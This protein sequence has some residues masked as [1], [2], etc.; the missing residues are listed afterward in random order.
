MLKNIVNKELIKNNKI[1]EITII[2]SVI[3]SVVKKIGLI[4]HILAFVFGIMAIAGI[5]TDQSITI[6]HVLEIIT[7]IIIGLI[8]LQHTIEPII[9]KQIVKKILS[10][11]WGTNKV[12]TI[13]SAPTLIKWKG[14]GFGM[15]K[16]QKD[17]MQ[18]ENITIKWV[19]KNIFSKKL[20]SVST[21]IPAIKKWKKISNKDGD[22][23]AYF[24]PKYVIVDLTRKILKINAVLTIEGVEDEVEREF[25]FIFDIENKKATWSGVFP[26]H[27]FYGE[28]IW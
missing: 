23:I 15:V 20:L 14:G 9:K 3:S 26:S 6:R 24:I 2:G 13:I 25:L 19:R 18:T 8:I 16:S 22:I 4:L 10:K 7:V 12:E 27:P 11:F 21:N 5:V 17:I 28:W 1:Q